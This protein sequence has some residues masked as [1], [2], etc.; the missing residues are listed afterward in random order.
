MNFPPKFVGVPSHVTVV[1]TAVASYFRTD[2]IRLFEL[3]GLALQFYLCHYQTCVVAFEDINFQSM[4][5]IFARHQPASLLYDAWFANHHQGFCFCQR[6]FLLPL[7]TR[8]ACLTAWTFDGQIALVATNADADGT[9]IPRGY[10]ALGDVSGTDGLALEVANDEKFAFDFLE[11]HGWYLGANGV[12]GFN[13]V[14]GLGECFI[15]LRTP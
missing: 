10:V 9:A 3:V 12:Y 11:G 13:G 15:H 8:Q 14:G 4:F 7:E 2:E 6:D 5:A 1:E